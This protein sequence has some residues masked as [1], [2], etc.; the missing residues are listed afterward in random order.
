M[1]SIVK[2]H[3]PLIKFLGP[4]HLIQRKFTNT[5]I[6]FMLTNINIII[7][8]ESKTEQTSL[9]RNPLKLEPISS[10]KTINFKLEKKPLSEKEIE[11]I[12]VNI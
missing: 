4:R 7:I 6:N 10:S 11:M 9:L 12:M 8:I 5:L 2:K 1:A 3:I